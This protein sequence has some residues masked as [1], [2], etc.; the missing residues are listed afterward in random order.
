MLTAI[1]IANAIIALLCMLV[2]WRL[3][4][5]RLVFRQVADTLISVE[6]STHAVLYNAPDAIYQGQIGV[7]QL[8]EQ[9]QQL[10][11]KLRQARQLLMLLSLGQV[12]WLNWSISTRRASKRNK[13]RSR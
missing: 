13:R 4:S 11:P 9:Y 8:R 7:H 12:A 3:W 5:L 6:K 10:E 2:T 1:L